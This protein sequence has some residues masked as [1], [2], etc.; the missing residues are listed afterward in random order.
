MPRALPPRRHAQPCEREP[1]ELRRPQ[2][3]SRGGRRLAH[4]RTT[5]VRKRRRRW[6]GGRSAAAA[7]A[8]E[9]FPDRESLGARARRREASEAWPRG[10][11][12]GAVSKSRPWGFPSEPQKHPMGWQR[13]QRHSSFRGSCLPRRAHGGGR[14]EGALTCRPG[15]TRLWNLPWGQE[16]SQVLVCPADP[17]D[18]AGSRPCPTPEA[19]LR[20]RRGSWSPWLQGEPR[21]WRPRVRIPTVITILAMTAIHLMMLSS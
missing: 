15:S 10:C 13:G 3:R 6:E 11:S 9:R 7:V 14:L 12:E 16:A 5:R 1:P 19:W 17:A 4:D 20:R 21:S 8:G 18:P 2:K